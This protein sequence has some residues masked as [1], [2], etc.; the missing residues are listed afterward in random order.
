V[1][2]EYIVAGIALVVMLAW[3]ILWWFDSDTV[4]EEALTTTWIEPPE[5][6]LALPEED[7]KP[8]VAEVPANE[9]LAREIAFYVADTENFR[10]KQEL[11]ETD[12]RS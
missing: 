12:P 4:V 1:S 2:A 8:F 3:A 9:Y 7:N 11:E 5:K 6:P 10:A